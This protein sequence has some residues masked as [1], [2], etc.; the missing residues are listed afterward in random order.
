MD[1]KYQDYINRVVGMTQR[2]HYKSQWQLIQPSPKFR[3]GP[4][5]A[6]EPVPFP[7]YTLT[8]P[9]AAEDSAN[10]QFY[11]HLQES[12]QQLWQALPEQLGVPLPPQSFHLT[13]ADLVWESTYLQAKEQPEYD[14]T[15]RQQ[16]AEVFHKHQQVTASPIRLQV[17][18]FI[19]MTRA[20]AIALAPHTEADYDRLM[21]IRQSIY[22]T[23]GLLALGVE[24]QY[25]FTAHVTL[26][27]F[28]EIPE[29]LDA[30][31]FSDRLVQLNQ[32]FLEAFP[33]FDIDQIEL[34]KFDD[35]THYYRED[36]WPILNL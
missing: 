32:Q 22:Q 13:L 6:R 18:G 34:R 30:E 21:Q 25:N 1:E 33:E 8:T 20:I 14:L 7:G 29:H 12:Q 11:P 9:L 26:G 16:I 4:T 3:P 28:G 17:L 5:G 15:L 2:E 10:T 23:P 36:D 19:V 24:Q 27:Y 35:M 31:G